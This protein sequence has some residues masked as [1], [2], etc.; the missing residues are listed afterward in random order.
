MHK[1]NRQYERDEGDGKEQQKF[2]EMADRSH[3]RF[4]SEGIEEEG[5]RKRMCVKVLRRVKRSVCVKREREGGAGREE[6]RRE[7]C[8]LE[9][10]KQST[11]DS[12]IITQ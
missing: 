1:L 3:C 9:E 12:T 8:K 4:Q 5:D 2:R 11:R 7:L 10:E 6:Q